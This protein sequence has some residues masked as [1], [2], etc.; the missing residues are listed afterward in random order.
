MLGFYIALFQVLQICPKRF[1]IIIT[2][3]RPI[4]PIRNLLNLPGG[5]TSRAATKA[6]EAQHSDNIN[7]CLQSGTLY[8]RVTG[9]LKRRK[10][11]IITFGYRR[12]SNPLPL[13][14]KPS[15]LTTRPLTPHIA[16]QN[17][18]DKLIIY[19]FSKMIS[20]S[21]GRGLL[22]SSAGS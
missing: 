11:G 5:I 16:N 7:H 13:A 1:T 10:T 22:Q 4:Y 6:L 15:T 3:D 20:H 18:I 12:D 9:G 14:Q 19:I 8:C 17:L 21:S 2:P